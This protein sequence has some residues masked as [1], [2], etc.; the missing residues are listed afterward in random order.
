MREVRSALEY[1]IAEYLNNSGMFDCPVIPGEADSERPD[2]YISV[3]SINAEQRN[4]ASIVDMEIRVVCPVDGTSVSWL[5]N[6]FAEL[7]TWARTP[8]NILKGS[9]SDTLV[10]FG[11]T[12]L[13]Q[14][15][16]IKERQRA[17][18]LYF[19]VGAKA[20]GLTL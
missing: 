14:R 7:T 10:I 4:D 17:E 9:Q 3:V 13:S 5:Q 2:L 12:P 15:Q 19:K 8:G 18:I 16:E 20:L 1:E 11:I 6:T